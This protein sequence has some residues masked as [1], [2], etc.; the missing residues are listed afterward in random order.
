[1]AASATADRSQVD[2]NFQAF[3]ALLPELIPTHAGKL[4][5]MR[6]GEILGFFDS[7]AD[8]VRFG[9]D[10]FGE[11]GNFSVQEVTTRVVSL[12]FY[13]YAGGFQ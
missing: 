9:Q 2:I 8:A 7:Y 11:I 12:G 4:A 3:K 5:V 6:D 13:S 10:R 1:M